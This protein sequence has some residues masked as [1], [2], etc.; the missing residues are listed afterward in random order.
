MH[1]TGYGRRAY[2]EVKAKYYGT[3]YG[4]DAHEKEIS[5]QIDRLV[6]HERF[7]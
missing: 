1:A 5:S 6:E 4:K 2:F 7:E 3:C